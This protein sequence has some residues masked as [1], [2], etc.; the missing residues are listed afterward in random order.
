MIMV[1][2]RSKNESY[3][4]MLAREKLSGERIVGANILMYF[5]DRKEVSMTAKE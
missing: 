3:Y 4:E 1:I 5:L 2:S